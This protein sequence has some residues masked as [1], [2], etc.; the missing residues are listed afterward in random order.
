MT[1]ATRRRV[2]AA[3]ATA[4]FAVAAPLS[5]VAGTPS[6]DYV[7]HCMG[8]HGPGGV[9]VRGKVPPLRETLPAFARTA[10]GRAFLLSVPG[11]SNSSLTDSELAAVM[12]W[13]LERFAGDTP[14][15]Q[16]QPFTTEEV[17]RL[18]RPALSQVREARIA[19]L[20]T[21]AGS[22]PVPSDDY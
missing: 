16:R 13:L 18:R 7:T 3:A 20:R 9:G 17:S 11:A 21:L 12:S 6:Q 10:A 5:S 19:T 8:C 15:D 14:A 22:G 4:V 2:A 1:R